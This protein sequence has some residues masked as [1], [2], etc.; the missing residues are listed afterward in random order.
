VPEICRP[1]GGAHPVKAPA[2]KA[3]WP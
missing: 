2:G 3:P 1:D